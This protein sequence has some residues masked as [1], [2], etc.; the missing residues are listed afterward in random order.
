MS[1]LTR[2]PVNDSSVLGQTV[3]PDDDGRLFPLDASLE[4]CAPCDVLV[5][6]VQDGI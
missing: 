2:L 5:E 3:I 6:E 1:A 4:V